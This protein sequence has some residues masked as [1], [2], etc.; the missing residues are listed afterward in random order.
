MMVAWHHPQ[1]AERENGR[2]QEFRHSARLCRYGGKDAGETV[3][4][5]IAPEYPHD[6][7]IGPLFCRN[8]N[9]YVDS[10]PSPHQSRGP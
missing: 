1:H 5:N 8:V 10:E 3:I 7:D 2:C 9:R 4:R 6:I